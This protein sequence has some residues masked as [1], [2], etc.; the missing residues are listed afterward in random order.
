MS[1]GA[2]RKS[3]QACAIEKALMPTYAIFG[4]FEYRTLRLRSTE[5]SRKQF[6]G[7]RNFIYQSWHDTLFRI[8]YP[9]LRQFDW[10]YIQL[11]FILEGK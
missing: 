4:I 1:D 5:E 6:L 3:Q 10:I 8:P 11:F 7:P 9:A 2:R